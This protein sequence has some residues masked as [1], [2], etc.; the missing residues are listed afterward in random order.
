M[1]GDVGLAAPVVGP[2]GCGFATHPGDVGINL[3]A[4]HA[5]HKAREL[6]AEH[7]NHGE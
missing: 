4:G 6:Q 3:H 7:A 5:G 1:Y 2:A